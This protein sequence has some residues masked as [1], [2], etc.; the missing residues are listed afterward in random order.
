MYISIPKLVLY[1]L[2]LPFLLVGM[3]LYA[4][5]AFF[6]FIFLSIK[7]LVLFF[8][9]RSLYEDLPEDIEAKKRLAGETPKETTEVTNEDISIALGNDNKSE[10]SVNTFQFLQQTEQFMQLQA[11]LLLGMCV[12]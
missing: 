6:V 3:A 2:V 11:R 8:T 9:G 12:R 4:V 5:V 10:Q 1:V 7:G